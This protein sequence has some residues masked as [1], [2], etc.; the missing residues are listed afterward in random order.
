MSL[1][2]KKAFTYDELISCAKGE[3]FG[4]G[5]PQLPLP[6]ML[7]TDRITSITETGGQFNKGFIPDV[8]KSAQ[9]P[10]TLIWLHIDLNSSLPTIK[11][12]ELFWDLLEPGGVVLL[13]DYAWIG[14]KD[15]QKA[16]EEWSMDKEMTLFHLPTGQALLIKDIGIK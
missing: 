6:P 15:T 3:L 14:H 11:S 16:V 8:F 9:N 13:D 1:I 12:L 7:M 10:E 5:N 4:P 2:H